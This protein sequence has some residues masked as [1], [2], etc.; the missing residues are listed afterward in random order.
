MVLPAEH[1]NQLCSRIVTRSDMEVARDLP[2]TTVI[3]AL[4]QHIVPIVANESATI[5]GQE[6]IVAFLK[7]IK[8]SDMIDVLNV[9]VPRHL[10]VRNALSMH[11]LMNMVVAYVMT[12]G[13]V[14]IVN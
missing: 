4:V 10:I 8:M 7:M 6:M 14:R 13:V 1:M 12:D 11:I 5:T 3:S 2:H 9:Q